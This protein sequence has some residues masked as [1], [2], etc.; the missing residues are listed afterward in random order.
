MNTC[1][2][3]SVRCRDTAEVPNT[4]AA[5]NSHGNSDSESEPFHPSGLGIIRRSL[6]ISLSRYIVLYC[7]VLIFFHCFP[8][9]DIVSHS[10]CCPLLFI[11][12][13]CFPLYHIHNI[14]RRKTFDKSFYVI[15]QILFR[16]LINWSCVLYH[17]HNIK[18]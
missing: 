16:I 18:N 3:M 1:K 2:I 12:T 5:T 15:L 10:H 6:Y 13:C 9:F 14:K 7:I 17:I 11:A 8:L 4:D